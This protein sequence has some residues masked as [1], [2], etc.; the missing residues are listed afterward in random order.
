V[1]AAPKRRKN[2]RPVQDS[3]RPGWML[4]AIL[5]CVMMAGIGA[6]Y[7]WLGVKKTNKER[8]I[9]ELGKDIEGLARRIREADQKISRRL[10]P[11]DLRARAESA[12][13]QLKPID[14]GS[15][16]RLYHLPDPMPQSGSPS[17]LE[18]NTFAGPARP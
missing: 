9:Y 6:C 1:S 10:T 8:Q 5:F 16:G 18:S 14:I 4:N 3:L 17:S 12:G 11:E 7:V 15:K 2:N 13:L